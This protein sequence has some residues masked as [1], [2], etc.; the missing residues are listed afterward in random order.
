MGELIKISCPKCGQVWDSKRGHGRN[1][2]RLE[3]IWPAFDESVQAQIKQ[4]AEDN[5]FPVFEFAYKPVVCKACRKVE[6]VP[7]LEFPKEQTVFVGKCSQCGQAA[8]IGL[9]DNSLECPDCRA[10]ALEIERIG[11]WD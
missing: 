11:F 4:L 6:S 10:G 2:A 9:S 3:K 1:Q 5:P 8:T 7:V